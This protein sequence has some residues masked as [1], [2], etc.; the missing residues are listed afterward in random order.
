MGWEG[1]GGALK[2]WQNKSQTKIL[3]V[4]TGVL[5]EQTKKI[6]I[7]K[8]PQMKAMLAQDALQREAAFKQKFF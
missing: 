3:L 4:E 5:S 8:L 7:N 6:N 2:R 1:K